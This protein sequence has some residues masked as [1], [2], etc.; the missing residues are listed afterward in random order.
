MADVIELT[1]QLAALAAAPPADLSEEA[2]SGLFAAINRARDAFMG[3]L[4]ASLRFSFGVYET[5]AVR[6]AIEM[7]LF[8]IAASVGEPITSAELAEKAGADVQLVSRV[9][10]MLAGVALFS[11]TA[12]DT[13]LAKPLAGVFCTGSPFREVIIHLGSNTSAVALLPEFFAQNG[14]KNPDDAFNGPWQFAHKTDKHYFD[15]LSEHPTLQTA[16]NTVMGIS[17]MGQVDWTEFYPVEERLKVESSER[18]ALVDVGGGIGHD[19]AA[20]KSKLPNLQ[21]KFVFEDLPIV[22]NEAKEMP[23]GIVGVGHDFFK[24]QPESVRGA[25]AYYLRTVLHDWPDKQASTIIRHIKDVMV[26]DSILLINE[27][28]LPESGVSLYQ[29]ELDIAMMTYFSSLDRTEKQFKALLEDEGFECTGTY[30]PAVQ[31]PGAGT[32]MEFR[33][34]K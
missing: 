17:R 7:K 19:V 3:P 26:E 30:K 16:F 9:M 14:Y 10:R 32:V 18:T 21:G 15:W 34:K 20:L 5:I 12:P 27:N 23:E 33:V 6:L 8:D 22:V 1:K 28:M 4:D 11:E 31:I 13:F 25:K 2:R 24:P 29:A